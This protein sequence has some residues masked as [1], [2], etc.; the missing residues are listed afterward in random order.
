VTA[1]PI[2]P[3]IPSGACPAVRDQAGAG[4]LRRL[5]LASVPEVPAAAG[6]ILYGFG[7]IDAPGRVAD[8]PVTTALGWRAG[9][10]LTLTAAAGGVIAPRGPESR[11]TVP[12]RPYLAI[13]APLRRRCGLEPGDRILLAVFPSSDALA[14]YSFTVVDQAL[15]KHAP[16]PLGEGD[17]HERREPR[18]ACRVAAGGGRGRTGAARADGPVPRGSHRAPGAWRWCRRSRST[19]RGV[20]AVSAGTRRAYGSY[21]N[22]ILEH[23]GDRRLGEPTPS[24]DPAADDVG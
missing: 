15:R 12:T 17:G 7:R 8:A 18:G 9:D 22:R 4:S 20:A 5:P 11:V 19:S 3:V 2:P 23:C 6:D 13:P 16:V 21:W 1:Q 14:A 24:G 10:R